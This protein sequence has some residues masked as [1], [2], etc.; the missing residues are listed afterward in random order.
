MYD[1]PMLGA[2]WRR[3]GTDRTAGRCFSTVSMQ[4]CQNGSM[5]LRRTIFLGSP[6]TGQECRAT[7]ASP[8]NRRQSQRQS[9]PV[10][11]GWGESQTLGLGWHSRTVHQD[12]DGPPNFV[13]VV[14]AMAAMAASLQSRGL[15]A[16][17]SRREEGHHHWRPREEGQLWNEEAIRLTHNE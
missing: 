9:H 14:P 5:L 12:D 4:L 15:P 10:V 3:R 13:P 2:P 17:P 1:F 8:L 11:R 6:C 7:V 16:A